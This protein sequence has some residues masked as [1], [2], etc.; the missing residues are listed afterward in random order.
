[1]IWYSAR[2]LFRCVVQGDKRKRILFEETIFLVRAR[3][4]EE[5]RKN[6][7]AIARKKQ[8]SYNN[9]F[10]QKVRWKFHKLL[11]VLPLIDQRMVPGAEVYWR[12]F[13]RKRA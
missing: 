5:A 7:L 8:L 2:V 11:E 1:M 12:L 4:D 13:E 10:K 3:Y 6:A 9:M